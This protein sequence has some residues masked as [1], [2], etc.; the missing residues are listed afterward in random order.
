MVIQGLRA[1][2]ENNPGFEVVRSY[3]CGL[4]AV[5]EYKIVNPDIVLMDINMPVINGFDTS[6]RILTNN[7]DAKIIMLSMEVTKPYIKKAL[8]E[9]IKGYVS[10]SADINELLKSI[11]TVFNGG[12]S[13]NNYLQIAS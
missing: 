1:L 6:S 10:K 9:G 11:K 12:M 8:E 7:P 3:S 4:E 5:K 2:I 13:F